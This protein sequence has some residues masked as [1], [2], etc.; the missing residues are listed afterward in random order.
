MTLT[1]TQASRNNPFV[2]STGIHAHAERQIRSDRVGRGGDEQRQ[3][4]QHA[5]LDQRAAE[6]HA[7]LERG[8]RDGPADQDDDAQH[9]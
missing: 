2:R 6:R 3:G 9:T 8:D 4:E 7:D 5:E 1:T